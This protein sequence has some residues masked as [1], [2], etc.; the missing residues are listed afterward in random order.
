[1]GSAW[2]QPVPP[3]E[4]LR[5][6]LACT[7]TARPRAVHRLVPDACVDLVCLGTGDLIVCGP[8]TTS[9]TFRL[10]S[11]A[12]AVGL[13]FLPGALS[14]SCTIDMATIRERRVPAEQLFG[15]DRAD[16]LRAGLRARF[17]DD[18]LDGARIALESACDSWRLMNDPLA[19]K[20]TE[21]LAR[22]PTTS[23]TDLAE[24]LHMSPR[25]LH[26][27]CLYL[28]GYGI[29]T[30][31]RIL[32]FH[33]FTEC[34]ARAPSWSVARL[35]AESGYHDES[36]LARD[37]R[38]MTGVTPRAFLAEWFPTFPTGHALL[39]TL[40]PSVRGST[41]AS[42]AHDAATASPR[43]TARLVR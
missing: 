32:R 3:P 8:E 37:C 27:R 22:S 39:P 41:N 26:R 30:L 14:A 33:R 42:V 16:T 7:W 10:P 23:V 24:A 4:S 15:A 36:H 2:Y 31:A 13:R 19:A 40:A 25:Q 29:S 21:Y 9:W 1:M 18:D 20:V 34:A 17:L 28:F 38:A 12:V 6:V 35:A 5:S 43:S 11:D